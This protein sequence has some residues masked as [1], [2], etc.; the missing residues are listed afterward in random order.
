MGVIQFYGYS[1]NRERRHFAPPTGNRYLELVMVQ[2]QGY[3]VHRFMTS[4]WHRN[5]INDVK[6]KTR[7]SGPP[8]LWRLAVAENPLMTLKIALLRIIL[9]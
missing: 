5:P 4:G 2:G 6:I 1:T 9:T 8:Y 7:V 3:K